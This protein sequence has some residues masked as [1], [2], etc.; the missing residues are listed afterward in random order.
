MSFVDRNGID[1][2]ARDRKDRKLVLASQRGD[3][4][5][6][7]LLLARYRELARTRGSSYYLR[8]ADQEDVQQEAM[9]GLFKAIRDFD[10]THEVS[11]IGFA[12]LCIHRQIQTAVKT[13]N[14]K[15]HDPLQSYLS[16]DTHDDAG[17]DIPPLTDVL[18]T[19]GTCQDPITLMLAA[20]QID[21]IRT[22][23]DR[24]LSSLER[25]VLALVMQGVRYVEIAK[26]VDSHTK[27]VDN[28]LQRARQKL[29][30]Y[31]QEEEASPGLAAQTRR[32]PIGRV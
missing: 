24:T 4:K 22:H 29:R 18:P 21:G 25:E 30:D 28:A 11:F 32:L 1:R 13:A 17:A 6:A 20:E 5:S 2:E 10:P 26:M 23:L 15:K 9:I 16:L 7:E 8:G 31:L 19:T 3:E 12:D 27:A 14:R